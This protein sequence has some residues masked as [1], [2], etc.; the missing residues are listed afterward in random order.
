[1][2]NP[3]ETYRSVWGD[4]D[5]ENGSYT[6]ALDRVEKTKT[7]R[8][9]FTNYPPALFYNHETDTFSGIFYEII[10]AI[11][12]KHEWQIKWSEETGYGVVIDGLDHNRFDLFGSTV[13]PTPERKE[14]AS[15]QNLYTRVMHI[16]G[17][18]QALNMKN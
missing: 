17:H 5:N 16:H 15:F 4:E 18:C 9:A 10:T 14:K 6:S 7:L 2:E 12:K 3:W 1:M 13:W 8:V 11:A